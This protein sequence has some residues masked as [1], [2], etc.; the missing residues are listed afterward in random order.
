M[1]ATH[2]PKTSKQLLSRYIPD[3][4][5]PV[6]GCTIPRF[7]LRLLSNPMPILIANKRKKP[8]TLAQLYPNARI[9]NVTSQGSHCGSSVVPSICTTRFRFYS[10]PIIPPPRSKASGRGSRSSPMAIRA[11]GVELVPADLDDITTL[12]SAFQ[13]AYGRQIHPDVMPVRTWLRNS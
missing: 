12:E 2:R 5:N 4:L 13:G 9:P 8:E 10:R 6:F 7:I 3:P 1:T 11:L